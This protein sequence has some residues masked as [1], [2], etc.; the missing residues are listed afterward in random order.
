MGGIELS[1]LE[2]GGDEVGKGLGGMGLKRRG[3][4]A[5]R[6]REGGGCYVLGGGNYVKHTNL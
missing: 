2:Y 3:C 6:G 1:E 4:Y 5:A